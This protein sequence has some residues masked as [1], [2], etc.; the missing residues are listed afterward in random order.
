LRNSF[1][2]DEAQ[3][4]FDQPHDADIAIAR[5]RLPGR[6]DH[7]LDRV[8]VTGTFTF[9]QQDVIEPRACLDDIKDI[10]AA[11]RRREA[12]DTDRDDTLAPVQLIERGNRVRPRL[13]FEAGNNGVLE[14]DEDGICRRLRCLFQKTRRGGRHGEQRSQAG[15]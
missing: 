3:R 2:V 13:Q 7:H 6:P 10:A 5:S 1:H 4:R 15:F 12:V 8:H 14:I 11:P 9:W